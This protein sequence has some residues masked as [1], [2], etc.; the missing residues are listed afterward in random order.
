[1]SHAMGSRTEQHSGG[2]ANSQTADRT[3]FLTPHDG[4]V[5]RFFKFG[6]KIT[7]HPQK[8]GGWTRFLFHRTFA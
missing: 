6:F 3:L 4:P 1:M 7:G 5:E 2:L 8:T